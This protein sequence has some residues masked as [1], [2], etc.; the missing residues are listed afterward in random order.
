[1]QDEVQIELGEGEEILAAGEKNQV[2]CICFTALFCVATFVF[3]YEAFSSQ[4]LYMR[5]AFGFSAILL[6]F[7]TVYLLNSYKYNQI[8]LTDKRI[9][10][11]Q[12]DQIEGVPHEEIKEFIGF[13]TI[14]LKSKRKFFFAYTNL[15]NLQ[16]QFKEI[17]PQYKKSFF[18]LKD[19]VFV[20]FVIL[21]ILAAK[22][23]P[24]QIYNLKQA[25]DLRKQHSQEVIENKDEYMQYLEKV[26]KL[27]WAP[28]KMT[29][30]ANVTVEFQI[31]PDG[32]VINEKIVKTSGSR[33]LD[34]SALFAVRKAKPLRRLPDDLKNEKEVIINFTF[35]YNLLYN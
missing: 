6:P 21:F 29:H 26:L 22:F 5:A 11:T 20:T 33:E 12:K 28:P 1:M 3:F 16:E 8:Y 25:Y 27:H 14:Y 34:N 15:D 35:D 23:V 10:I 18:T 19:I 9:I 31:L 13:D 17:Y 24:E 7:V 30:H 2:M 32:S 4:P